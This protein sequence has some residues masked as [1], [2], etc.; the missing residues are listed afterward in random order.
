MRSLRLLAIVLVVPLSVSLCWAQHTYKR[1]PRIYDLQNVAWRLSF[2]ETLGTID[3]DVTNTLI[4]LKVGLKEVWFDSDKLNIKQ[5]WVNGKAA[6]FRTSD[7][8]VYVTLPKVSGPKDKLDVRLIYNGRPEAGIYFIPAS[9]AFPAKTSVV[10]TQGEMIDTRS[11]IPTY[12]WPDDKATF[13][14]FV[15]VPSNYLVISNGKMI[16]SKPAGNMKVVHYRMAN[17]MSTYLISLVTGQYTQ[18]DDGK[19]GNVPVRWNVPVGLEAMG[20]ATFGGTDKMVDVFSEI[21]GFPYPYAKFDQSAVPDYMFGGMENITAV[22]QTIDALFPPEA[23]PVA[24]AE[25][26]VLHELAHQWFG[27]TVTCPSWEHAWINEGWATFLPHFYTRVAHGKDAYDLDR[28]N[29]LQ[30]GYASTIGENR[31]VVWTGYE[32]PIDEFGG[33]IYGGGATRM[34]WLMYTLGEDK[35]WKALTNY[36]NDYKYKNV[37]TEMFFDSFSKSSGVNFDTFRRQWFYTAAMP[38]IT[39]KRD[40]KDLL[41]NQKAPFFDLPLPVWILNG[42]T[43]EKKRVFSNNA[44]TRLPLG[45]LA[46]KPVLLDP[47]VYLA[48]SITYD[49]PISADEYIAMY[50]NAPNAAAKARMGE[51]MVSALS[52][53]QIE[54]IAREE[55]SERLFEQIIP[56]LKNESYLLEITQSE[57]PKFVNAA[58]TALGAAGRVSDVAAVRLR[59]LLETHPNIIV[60]QTAMRSLLNNVKDDALADRAWGMPSFNEDFREAALGYYIRNDKDTAR[61]L[62]LGVMAHPNSEDLRRF[63][64]QS[65]GNMKDK[66]GDRRV[67]NALVKVAQERSFGARTDAINALGAYGDKAAVPILKPITTNSLHFMRRT[68]R[69]VVAQLGG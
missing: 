17:P 3:G 7:E 28:Y 18:G 27:D 30:G 9:R 33:S 55:R 47:E 15:K 11:W 38:Q 52:T 4:P 64:I 41:I 36:L 34:F 60:K 24:S 32:E 16:G 59:Q 19:Y 22:T 10:Y 56:L 21:T 44:S 67:F 61:E 43:W 12:D 45:D 48:A 58:A 63:C 65:L 2:D 39:V 53:E 54:M 20:K 69:R 5:A 50:R 13:D 23:A 40:G 31:P 37:T 66:P 51:K 1:S 25:G 29:T 57:N 35:F 62:A 49:Y 68:A 42:R 14:A 8:K 6:R 26:L 46:G